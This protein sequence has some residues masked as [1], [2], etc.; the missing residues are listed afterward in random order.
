[1]DFPCSADITLPDGISFSRL[2][3]KC[4]PYL[5]LYI[6]NPSKARVK[7]TDTGFFKMGLRCTNIGICRPFCGNMVYLQSRQASPVSEALVQWVICIL[8]WPFRQR[9]ILCLG[10]AKGIVDW[11]GISSEVKQAVHFKDLFSS[12]RGV[13]C[14]TSVSLQGL[15]MPG[16][17]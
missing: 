12:S 10:N 1:M 13:W 14:Q 6:M 15:W 3:P 11:N 9:Q 2:C 17:N 4:V 8:C 16:C 5:E 7:V